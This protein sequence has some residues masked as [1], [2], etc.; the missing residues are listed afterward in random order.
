MW[1]G[2]FGSVGLICNG[3]GESGDVVCLGRCGLE[4]GFGGI[5]DWLG[6]SSFGYGLNDWLGDVVGLWL[7]G[8]CCG[9]FS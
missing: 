3:V 5:F 6:W 1:C 7:C 9:E 2:E 4:V 8:K